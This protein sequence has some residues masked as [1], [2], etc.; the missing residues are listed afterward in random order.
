MRGHKMHSGRD[1]PNFVEGG[2]VLA[3]SKDAA[4]FHFNVMAVLSGIFFI[5]FIVT[6]Y[7]PL[8]LPVFATGCTAYFYYPLREK[9]PRIGA[10]QYGIFV[11]G[12]GLIPWRVIDD[13]KLI[14]FT[15]RFAQTHELHIQ[16]KV[17]LDSALYADWRKLPVWRLLMKLPWS[18]KGDTIIRIP[19]KPFAQP[20]WDIHRQL[21]R[22]MEYYQ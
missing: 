1:N 8:L 19:L 2:Y 4:D 17:A 12:L 21:K 13:I 7:A 6:A 5:L 3:Y 22:M 10:W 9:T 16:L 11:D 14:T 15:S 18:M 20:A